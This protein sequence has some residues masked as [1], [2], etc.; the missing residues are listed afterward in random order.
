MSIC[1]SLGVPPDRSGPC[2][3]FP[4]PPP[5]SS[6]PTSAPADRVLFLPL[7]R[8]VSLCLLIPSCSPSPAHSLLLHHFPTSSPAPLLLHIPSCSSSCLPV[9]A[10]PLQPFALVLPLLLTLSFF[11][12]CPP[13][14]GLSPFPAMPPPLCS[15]S[16]LCSSEAKSPHEST[17]LQDRPWPLRLLGLIELLGPVGLLGLLGPVGLERLLGPYCP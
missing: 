1:I 4:G 16:P 12:P 15:P 5:G 3:H 9:S 17:A 6:R 8:H 2:C 7:H 11:F 10:P 13:S 14:P